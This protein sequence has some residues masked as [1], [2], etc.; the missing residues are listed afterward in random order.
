MSIFSR[1][2]SKEKQDMSKVVTAE[3][4]PEG[5]VDRLARQALQYRDLPEYL[6]YPYQLT[7]QEPMMREV[8]DREC[9]YMC[10]VYKAH[11]E[12][13]PETIDQPIGGKVTLFRQ[14][15]YHSGNDRLW[16]GVT[17]IKT[18]DPNP[19]VGYDALRKNWML[20]PTK[21]KILTPSGFKNV[22][23]KIHYLPMAPV[24]LG[25]Y[26]KA[27]GLDA[28]ELWSFY[29]S[30]GDSIRR[31]FKMFMRKGQTMWV[32]DSYTTGKAALNQFDYIVPS[33]ILGSFF[34]EE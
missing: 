33:L 18:V 23:D 7:N 1:L 21:E 17:T 24:F 31:C 10:K 13:G 29:F 30:M 22:P 11:L 26:A 8:H 19:Q 14:K 3:S 4:A 15:I 9:G 20:A 32:V 12:Q 28:A 34:P 27:H 16:F 6:R 2:F 25:D 5:K